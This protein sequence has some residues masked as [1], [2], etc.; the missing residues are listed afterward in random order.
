MTEAIVDVKL[1]DRTRCSRGC[2][3]ESQND[4]HELPG[5]QVLGEQVL[6]FPTTQI[7]WPILIRA[8]R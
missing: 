6:D 4:P 2:F 8:Q 1:E 3:R 7:L 5:G